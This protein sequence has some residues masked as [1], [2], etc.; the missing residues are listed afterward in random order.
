MIGYRRT[1]GEV[2]RYHRRL[3]I[4]TEL[5]PCRRGLIPRQVLDGCSQRVGAIRKHGARHTIRAARGEGAVEAQRRVVV[6][7][8]QAGGIDAGGRVGE[9]EAHRGTIVAG[10]A[11]GR[12]RGEVQRRRGE[13]G[14]DGQ[15]SHLADLV[16]GSDAA[17]VGGDLHDGFVL[18]DKG[19]A[20]HGVGGE[21]IDAAAL[22]ERVER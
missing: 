21:Q 5:N 4:D 12:G 14:V 19:A 13:I 10:E 6:E 18:R 7:Q 17:A 16:Q 20:V 3:G 15:G 9:R 11:G 1:A 8:T 22:G 2:K